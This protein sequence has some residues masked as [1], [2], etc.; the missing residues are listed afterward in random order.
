[1]IRLKY[2]NA[3]LK[4]PLLV[5]WDRKKSYKKCSILHLIHQTQD[6]AYK[7]K[8]VKINSR[9]KKNTDRCLSD[10]DNPAL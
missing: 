1:M 5:Q 7:Q 4:T 10:K 3:P 9:R 8:A 6:S 2:K